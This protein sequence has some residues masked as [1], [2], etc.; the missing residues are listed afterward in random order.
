MAVAEKVGNG[1][2]GQ[3]WKSNTFNH[4]GFNIVLMKRLYKKPN[5][6]LCHD[7]ERRNVNGYKLLY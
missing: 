6:S 5:T 1:F 4:I 7:M 2:L 3:F